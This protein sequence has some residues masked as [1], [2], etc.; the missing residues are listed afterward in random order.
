[1][2]LRSLII[3]SSLWSYKYLA[4]GLRQVSL[5]NYNRHTSILVGY[6]KFEIIF[7]MFVDYYHPN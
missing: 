5:N 3:R 2:L 4:M 7:H 6:W 1:M